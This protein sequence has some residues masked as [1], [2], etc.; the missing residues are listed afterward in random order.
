MSSAHAG[1][2]AVNAFSAAPQI[3]A[4]IDIGSNS[5][6]LLVARVEERAVVALADTSAMLGLGAIVDR[7]ACLSLEVRG[8]LLDALA[9]FGASATQ[10]GATALAVLGTEPL[11]RAADRDELA[12]DILA[13]L[14]VALHVLSH[15]QEAEL[16]L[17]GVTGGAAIDTQ[18][19]VVDIGGG[20]SEYAVVAPGQPPTAGAIP[21]GSSRLLATSGSAGPLVL[22]DAAR[23]HLAGAP[24]A[25]PRRAVFTGGTA[26][27]LAKAQAALSGR[28]P[29]RPPRRLTRTQVEA[30]A[31]AL[32]TAGP[33]EFAARAR[34]SQVRA[35]LL[36][37][38]A[39]LVLAFMER[40]RLTSI[41]VS[42]ASLREGAVLALVRAGARWPERLPELTHGWRGGA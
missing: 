31:R 5:V 4:A 35:E 13:R 7:D 38:G 33:S 34:I 40:Y 18:L 6:H 30:L 37:A 22:L 11:R 27:N 29:D 17:L 42:G 24:P 2:P 19:L 10:E 3:V 9:D 41:E 32:A 1:P 16:T 14:G 21:T 15:A 20:S 25:N 36:P 39:A 12:A 28:G 8:R 23:R 26:T